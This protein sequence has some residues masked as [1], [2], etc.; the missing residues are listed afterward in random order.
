[1]V[2]GISK[3]V[4]MVKPQGEAAFEQAIFIVKDGAAEVTELELLRQAGIATAEEKGRHDGKKSLYDAAAF[5]SGAGLV[6]LSW[7]L[8]VLL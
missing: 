5:L 2:K 8:T 1:M 3:Q 4:I 7:L 6:G